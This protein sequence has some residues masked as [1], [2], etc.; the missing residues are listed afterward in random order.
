MV[1]VD[2]ML[3]QSVGLFT[4][5]SLMAMTLS[6]YLQAAETAMVQE[7]LGGHQW[8][9]DSQQAKVNHKATESQ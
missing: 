6:N 2:S 9:I 5:V 4:G 1:G 3:L 8:Y 7:I